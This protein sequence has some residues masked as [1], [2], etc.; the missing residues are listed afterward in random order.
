MYTTLPNPQATTKG[1]KQP[2]P[3]PKPRAQTH[4]I[5]QTANVPGR[6]DKLAHR[7]NREGHSLQLRGISP[8][9]TLQEYCEIFQSIVEL[10]QIIRE[11]TFNIE[12]YTEQVKSRMGQGKKAAGEEG[13]G[14]EGLGNMEG[15]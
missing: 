3:I 11:N 6:P 1:P 4:E 12:I 14:E 10:D 7:A 15:I 13:Q 9:L 2:P 5:R 8:K